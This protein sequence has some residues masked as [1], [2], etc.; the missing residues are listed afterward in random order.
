MKSIEWAAGLF[1]GE[2]CIHKR[3]NQF[4]FELKIDMT[5][6]D[7]VQEFAESFGVGKLIH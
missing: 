5:D 7:V 6:L 4:S 2:G 1:E 3:K